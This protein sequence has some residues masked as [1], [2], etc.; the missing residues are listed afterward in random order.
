MNDI[1]FLDLLLIAAGTMAA[2]AASWRLFHEAQPPP[3]EAGS[4]HH[5]LASATGAI[6]VWPPEPALR[7]EAETPLQRT[8]KRICVASRY[9]GIETFLEGAKLAYET[10]TRRFAEGNIER[11]R[12]LLSP[13]VYED[14]SRVIALRNAAGET[15]E[16]TFIGFRAAEVVDAE[17][18]NGRAWIEVRFVADVISVS[19]D[20]DGRNVAGHPAMVVS[21][22]GL[23]TFE[24]ELRAAEPTWVLTSIESDG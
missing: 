23:W 13:D 8:L 2:V 17:M 5:S 12:Y 6:E 18:S 7:D 9:P 10:I 4:K 1:G 19:R 16:Q 14:F 22:A 3:A 15:I 11:L 24:R 21:V 20:R